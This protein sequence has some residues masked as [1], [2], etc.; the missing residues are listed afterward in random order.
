MVLIALLSAAPALANMYNCWTMMGYYSPPPPGHNEGERLRSELRGK[1]FSVV[2]DGKVQEGSIE[3]VTNPS[4][5]DSE[6]KVLVT[7]NVG[8]KTV[9]VDNVNVAAL[10][11]ASAPAFPAV[12]PD[13]RR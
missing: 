10:K 3:S 6:A 1:K 11:Q 8:G 4:G 5:S 13:Q 2:F 7:L 9:Y 12:I